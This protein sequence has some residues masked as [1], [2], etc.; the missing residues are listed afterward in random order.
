ME[1]C[2]QTAGVLRDDQLF[3]G[4]DNHGRTGAFFVDEARLAEAGSQVTLRSTS[5]PSTPSLPSDSSRTIAAFSPDATGEDHGVETA[6]HQRGVGADV[7]RQA[8]AVD[9]HRAFSVGFFLVVVFYV[10]AVAGDFGQA[11]QGR[12]LWSAFC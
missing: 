2:G 3:V 6:V 11:Q 12:T 1:L 7:F 10:A 8:V 4:R 9:V 5:K